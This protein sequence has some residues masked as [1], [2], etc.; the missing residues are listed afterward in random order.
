[1][2]ELSCKT[3]KFCILVHTAKSICKWNDTFD[4]LRS[5]GIPLGV[6]AEWQFKDEEKFQTKKALSVFPDP[7]TSFSVQGPNGIPQRHLFWELPGDTV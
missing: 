3:E 5:S 1:M 7:T 6:D 2:N 4:E